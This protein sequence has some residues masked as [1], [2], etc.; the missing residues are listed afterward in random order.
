[1]ISKTAQK[2]EKRLRRH[3][4]IRAR[5]VGTKERPR[6]SVYRSNKF[7]YAQIIDDERGV[8]LVAASDFARKTPG[9]KA[10]KAEAIGAAVAEA[11]KAKGVE[12]VVFDRGGF[13]YTGRIKRLAEAARKGGLSF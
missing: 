13:I 7:I 6:L 1:M 5:V 12:K 2:N 4:R 9:T 11:A 8:T 10:V 3:G